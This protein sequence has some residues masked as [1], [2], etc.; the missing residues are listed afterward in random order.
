MPD[1]K[2]LP[3]WTDEDLD[4]LIG[5]PMRYEGRDDW[6]VTEKSL[7]GMAIKIETADGHVSYVG[8]VTVYW[9]E[10]SFLDARPVKRE[11]VLNWPADARAALDETRLALRRLDLV[12]PRGVPPSG[13]TD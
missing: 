5:L 3:H 2:N 8:P 9:G 10:A 13:N 6:V 11:S 12:N 1:D 7:S 4:A